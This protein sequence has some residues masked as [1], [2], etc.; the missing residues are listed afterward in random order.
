MKLLGYERIGRADSARPTV[1]RVSTLNDE[2]EPEY[3]RHISP[4]GKFQRDDSVMWSKAGLSTRETYFDEAKRTQTDELLT[5]V[6]LSCFIKSSQ[7][8]KR[9]HR[10]TGT[11]ISNLS[12]FENVDEE[13]ENEQPLKSHISLNPTISH[14]KKSPLP[15]V[16]DDN[17]EYGGILKIRK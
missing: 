12:Q 6:G 5:A 9:C 11:E 7:S 10:R 8:S 16:I 13:I 15:T 2:N 17:N 14:I 4:F 1:T 3:Q